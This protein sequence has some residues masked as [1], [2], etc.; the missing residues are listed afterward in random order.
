[1]H[2]TELLRGYMLVG[3]RCTWSTYSA[4]LHTWSLK[5][6]RSYT[7]PWITTHSPP[8]LLWFSRS[9]GLMKVMSPSALL[10]EG[11]GLPM[12]PGQ[13]RSSSSSFCTPG[14]SLL[15]LSNRSSRPLMRG[16][17][18]DESITLG[19]QVCS[20][21]MEVR[22]SGNNTPVSSLW[23]I[24]DETT[25]WRGPFDASD[26]ATGRISPAWAQSK[27]A[28][29][30]RSNAAPCCLELKA[31]SSPGKAIINVQLQIVWNRAFSSHGYLWERK[32]V[33]IHYPWFSLR[34]KH[35]GRKDAHNTRR[36][37]SAR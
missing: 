19:I 13:A 2:T 16:T 15:N 36:N 1:M 8:S 3:I 17:V 5:S 4:I 18:L 26:E 6:W 10:R 30:C 11:V 7:F 35:K 12:P 25:K 22:N 21:T 9:S 29:L 33:F 32:R 23:I 27:V 14:A 24:W 20:R 37:T 34:H 28:Y 31:L